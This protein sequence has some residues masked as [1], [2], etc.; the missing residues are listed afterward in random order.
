M[1]DCI[2][3]GGGISGLLSA[4]ELAMAGLRV[5]V[6]ERGETGRE[7]SWAGGGILSPLYPWRYPEPVTRLARWSQR[8][9][10]DFSARIA[11]ETGIDPEW[12]PSGMLMLD[13]GESAQAGDWAREQGEFLEVLEPAAARA[14]EPALGA[15]EGNA[16]WMPQVAQV[17]NPRLMKAL[18]HSV[19]AL[20][21]EVREHEEVTGLDLQGGR[22]RGVRTA[23]GP[24]AAG[25]VLIT[26]GA[27]SAVLPGVPG[28]A[29]SIVPVKG[30]MIL[31][32]GPCGLLKRMVLAGGRYLIPRRD[33]RILAGSTLEHTGFDKSLTPEASEE[34]RA[35]AVGL[36]P[37]LA[38]CPIEHH[39]AGLRP[40]SPNGI[41]Y[42][43]EHPVLPGLFINAGHF[44]NGVVL[45]LASAR[46]ASDAVLGRTPAVDPAPYG[47]A[48]LRE[49]GGRA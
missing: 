23:T 6:L 18:K 8:R 22:L 19:G 37:A 40:G 41:P 21:V 3:I 46:L 1:I 12:E 11:A 4:R 35:A 10:A 5:V 42:I 43:G 24:V 17:R 32:H 28:P 13:A 7:A 45:A 25:R 20:G 14:E 47:W 33:G 49:P 38:D 2:I 15:V 48:A 30:Q 27:W 26:G 16:I 44:R 29:V 31:F 39:W 36:V 9:Y 34:L